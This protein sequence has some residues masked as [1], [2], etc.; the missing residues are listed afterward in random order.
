[1]WYYY[2]PEFFLD[3]ETPY[4]EKQDMYQLG[5]TIYELAAQKPAYPNEEVEKFCTALGNHTAKTTDPIYVSIMECQYA[6]IP[7]HYS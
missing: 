5:S 7:S 1:M 2:P 6:R 3:F 4:G